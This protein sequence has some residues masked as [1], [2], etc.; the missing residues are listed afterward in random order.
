MQILRLASTF[1]RQ[2]ENVFSDWLSN[3]RLFWY[4][5]DHNSTKRNEDQKIDNIL[6]L[7]Q[8]YFL[9]K[10][11]NYGRQV[12]Y[13]KIEEKTAMYIYSIMAN[14]KTRNTAF[15]WYYCG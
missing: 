9:M 11:V 13:V 8:V 12:Y 2:Q 15:H 4:Q 1:A 14:R 7:E 10:R 6:N 3:F 5:I